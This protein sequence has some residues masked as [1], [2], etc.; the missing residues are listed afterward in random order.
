M[1]HSYICCC[2]III[3]VRWNHWTAGSCMTSCSWPCPTG[4]GRTSGWRWLPSCADHLSATGTGAA[5]AAWYF[6][7]SLPERILSRAFFAI[8]LMTRS[9]CLITAGGLS[10]WIVTGSKGRSSASAGEDSSSETSG[11]A[12]CAGRRLEALVRYTLLNAARSRGAAERY[13]L[14]PSGWG[15]K[16]AIRPYI[17]STTLATHHRQQQPPVLLRLCVCGVY[18]YLCRS[19]SCAALALLSSLL[20]Y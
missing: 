14:R 15:F 13:R 4:W 7:E 18:T 19:C 17:C 2:Y 5:A 12:A 16:A 10:G 8:V 9:C 11:P 1:F 6:L 3:I 20:Y